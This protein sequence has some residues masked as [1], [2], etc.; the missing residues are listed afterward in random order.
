MPRMAHALLVA[1]G[2]VS[3]VASLASC[4][5]ED[6]VLHL[7]SASISHMLRLAPEEQKSLVCLTL[8]PIPNVGSIV[9]E[10]MHEEF[11]PDEMLCVI[12]QQESSSGFSP[13]SPTCRMGGLRIPVYPP[14]K[15]EQTIKFQIVQP[16]PYPLFVRAISSPEGAPA[17]PSP[18]KPGGCPPPS[19]DEESCQTEEIDALGMCGNSPFFPEACRDMCAEEELQCLVKHQDALDDPDCRLAL[20]MWQE[21]NLGPHLLLPMEI[22]SVML[23]ATASFTLLCTV[24]RCCFRRLRGAAA[25]TSAPSLSLEEPFDLSDVEEDEEGGGTAGG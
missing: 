16:L 19:G 12:L 17:P 1:A 23:L 11:D 21:C 14:S 8:E 15:A 22:A 20:R 5:E 10:F 25:R 6:R 9:V 4:S 2:A 24:L 7:S 18:I 13:T 3:G